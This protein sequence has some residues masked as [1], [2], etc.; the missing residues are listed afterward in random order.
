MATTRPTISAPDDQPRPES[1][2]TSELFRL[3]PG[4]RIHL[5]ETNFRESQMSSDSRQE[6]VKLSSPVTRRH[7][8]VVYRLSVVSAVAGGGLGGTAA[9]MP[10]AA[11][12]AARAP[13]KSVSRYIPRAIRD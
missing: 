11:A 6:V 5:I 3:G 7:A 2:Y 8:A 4:H 9:A 1:A 12:T 10:S 13:T